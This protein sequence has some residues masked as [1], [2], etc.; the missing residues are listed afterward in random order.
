[1]VR[2]SHGHDRA[3]ARRRSSRADVRLQGRPQLRRGRVG[4]RADHVVRGGEQLR[5]AARTR[6]LLLHGGPRTGRR[7]PSRLRRRDA[8]ADLDAAFHA[9]TGLVSA[10]AT[11][12]ILDDGAIYPED[13]L[14]FS[15][16]EGAIYPTFGLASITATSDFD[17]ALYPGNG[18]VS[19]S[20]FKG[21][22]YSSGRLAST[23]T[24]SDFEGASF[25][26]VDG[27]VSAIVA[28]ASDFKGAIDSASGLVSAT[29]S[30]FQ[31]TFSPT[32]GLV[33]SEF[34]DP[35]SPAAGLVSAAAADAV[36]PRT[37]VHPV[38]SGTDPARSGSHQGHRNVRRR[39]L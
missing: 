28:G 5:H 20:D 21:A 33:S 10:T 14:V 17:D 4:A 15:D 29:A 37:P 24:T 34:E 23:V 19:D 35:F 7:L 16:F 38:E 1:M 9:A 8:A 18:L 22:I 3:A 26:P 13:G 27:L 6:S 32:D 12:A 31:G 11:A 30:T 25:N 39:R 2:L 36:P